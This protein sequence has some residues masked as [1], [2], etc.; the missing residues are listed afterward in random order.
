MQLFERAS[1][2]IQEGVL[3][4]RPVPG[5]G[6][7]TSAGPALTKKIEDFTEGTLKAAALQL[8]SA[9]EAGL[10]DMQPQFQSSATD[11]DC[12]VLLFEVV[13]ELLKLNQLMEIVSSAV[14][15]PAFRLAITSP[16]HSGLS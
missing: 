13:C 6:L 11:M 10:P 16:K 15:S 14:A 2:L 9:V 12:N 8:E 1:Q 5:G 7:Q 4:H 3:Q